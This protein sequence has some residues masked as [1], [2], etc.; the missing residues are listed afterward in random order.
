MIQ[1]CRARAVPETDRPKSRRRLRPAFPA[2]LAVL[3]LAS[4]LAPAALAS[5]DS[6]SEGNC[7]VSI[8]PDRAGA[9]WRSAVDALGARLRGGD[10]VGL[11]CRAIAIWLE[12]GGAVLVFTTRDGRQA[13]RRLQS[14]EELGPVVDAL[15]VTLQPLPPPPRAPPSPPAVAPAPAEAPIAAPASSMAAVFLQLT[16]GTRISGPGS[17]ASP[18]LAARA[19][20]VLRNWELTAF[21]QWDPLYGLVEGGAP[22]GFAMSRYAAG[23]GMGRR[24][25]LAGTQVGLGVITSVAVVREYGREDE[26]VP[27]GTSTSLSGQSGAEPT[28]G[29]YLGL[30]WPRRSELRARAE[31]S[32]DAV[33]ARV[34]RPLTLDASLPSLPWWSTLLTIG[35]EWEV[36]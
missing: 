5:A 14:P 16:A 23:V 11:D 26:P 4:A 31:L 6:R 33:V 17:F 1:R 13:L 34:D 18:S 36:P 10:Q 35:M 32:A 25:A 7:A 19:G 9:P 21:A 29:A 2:A 20:V 12:T 28:V 24:V 27:E 15:R 8:S 3:P 22:P 30:V